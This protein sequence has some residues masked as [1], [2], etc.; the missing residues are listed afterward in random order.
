MRV[1]FVLLMLLAG[2]AF[3]QDAPN[4]EPPTVKDPRPL[5]AKP[6]LPDDLDGLFAELRKER[7]EAAADRISKRIWRMWGDSG[8]DS[9]NLLTHWA[10]R[11]MQKKKFNIA[12]DLLDQ[13]TTRKPDFAEG[14]NRRATLHFMRDQYLKSLADIERV[15]SIEPR[16]YGA[17]AGMGAILTRLGREREALEIWYKALALYPAMKSAQNAVVK[18]EESLAGRSL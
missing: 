13:V 15:L 18:L 1:F 12:L 3:A 2:P 14:W 9:I 17:L 4:A 16:H 10:S 5:A 7:D 6:D 11:A 8:D